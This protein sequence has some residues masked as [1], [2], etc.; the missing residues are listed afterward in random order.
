MLYCLLWRTSSK[1]RIGPA[2]EVTMESPQLESLLQSRLDQF[3]TRHPEAPSAALLI[4]TLTFLWKGASGFADPSTKTPMHPDDLVYIASVAKTMTATIALRLT[5]EGALGLDAPLSEYLDRETLDGLHEFEGHSYGAQ[6]TIRELLGH[7]SGLPDTFGSPGFMDL[8][9]RD[10][11]RL[12]TP[13]DTL[14]FIK[15]H[16]KPHFA[17]GAGFSYSDAN[18]NLVGLVIEAVTGGSLD[19]AYRRYVYEPLRMKSTYRRLVETPRA[20]ASSRVA[21]VFH[22]DIDFTTWRA[23]TADWAGGGLNSTLEDLNRFLRALARGE[24]FEK[25]STERAMRDWKHWSGNASYGLGVLRFD[26]DRDSDASRH[27]LGEIW[28]HIGAS[29]CFMFSWPAADATICGTF[30]QVACE[31]EILPFVVDVMRA[32]DDQDHTS[33]S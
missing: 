26:L 4:E 30:N 19:D 20:G 17:P 3:L 14:E 1:R 24:I 9:A 5:E 33:G 32:I 28:G 29:S 31:R 22:G 2:R 18:Y 27:G 25:A 7:R 11:N 13:Q 12:W 8:I 6:I 10:P 15:R 16:C 21:H 23:L